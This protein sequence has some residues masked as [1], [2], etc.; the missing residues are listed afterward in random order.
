MAHKLPTNEE[1][2]AVLDAYNRRQPVRVPVSLKTNPRIWV[3]DPRLNTEGWTFERIESDPETHVQAA[4]RYQH[5]LC[6]EIHRH[7]DGLAGIP[8][9]WNVNLWIYNVHEA[10]CLGAQVRYPP[11]QVPCT[12]PFLDETNKSAV[13]DC[14]ISRPLEM[15]FICRLLDFWKEMERICADLR[16]EGRPVKLWPFAIQ[17]TDGP[18][19]VGC[20]LRGGEF[21]VDL[22]DDPDYA[23]RLMGFLTDFAVNRRRAFEQHWGP[24]LAPINWMADDSIAM[25]SPQMYRERVLPFH[26]RFYE[27]ADP[28]LPRGM[29]LCGD[30]TR[31]FPAIRGEFGVQSF[32]TGFPVDHGALRRQLGPEVEIV[33][34]VEASLLLKG[35]PDQVHARARE[36]LQSGVMAGGRFVLSE[37]NNLPPCCPPD[38]LRAMYEA[39]LEFGRYDP[40]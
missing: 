10:A 24:C 34:G 12:E 38:N 11:G 33:G 8:D 31:H 19:T 20:N 25:L 30:A 4:L 16:F 35:T 29:H 9:E 22:L 15:P 40:A 14:D 23:D 5:H 37:A 3:Q 39:G 7:C 27:A 6:T 28:A 13:F 21:V 18:F 32:D 1:K 2:L 36:I 17:G 26:R